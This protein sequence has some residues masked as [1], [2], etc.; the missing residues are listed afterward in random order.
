MNP[1][2]TWIGGATAA[3]VLVFSGASLAGAMMEDDSA[4]ET[5]KLDDAIPVDE[6]AV[7][8]AAGPEMAPGEVVQTIPAATPKDEPFVVKRILEID[9]PLKYGDWYWDDKDVPDGPIVMTVDLDARVISVFKGGYEIGAAA[10]LLGTDEHPT[11]TGTF[12]ILWKQRHNVSEKYN[13]APM[14]WSMF[15]TKDGVAIHGGSTVENGYAS[16][17]CIAIPDELAS[18][19]FAIAKKGDKVIITRGETLEMGGQII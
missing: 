10:A 6:T 1:M 12:P 7:A 2:L 17:G 18:R 15:L 4:T 5:A 9:G 8:A 13:N 19:I 14:P 11:P 3:L 16:H